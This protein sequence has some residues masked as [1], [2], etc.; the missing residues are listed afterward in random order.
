MTIHTDQLL[1]VDGF[2]LLSRGYFATSYGKE[3]EQLTKNEQG[4]Y[5]NGVRVF[6]QKLCQLT[7]ENPY[8]HL[9]IA[10]DVKREDSIRR[11]YAPDYKGTRGELPEPLIEQYQTCC[12]LL[13]DIGIQQLTIPPYEADDI[14]GAITK[15]WNAE[16]ASLSAI[17]SNDR[18]LL[19][20][21]SETTT[22]IIAMKGKD[23]AIQLIDFQNQYGIT[24]T[25]WIDVKA[26][27]GDK[28]D[29]IPG[30]AGVGEKSA[31]PLIQQ[32][33]TVEVLYEKLANQEIDL[34]FKRYLKKLEAG[35][36]S[37]LLSKKLA[38]IICEIEEI[39]TYLLDEAKLPNDKEKIEDI[40]H[41]HGLKIQYNPRVY[42]AN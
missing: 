17:Y 15:K 38:T 25:Q 30:C 42:V 9:I 21:I 32:Y 5:I 4:Q 31:L 11:Q 24:P 35:Y 14:I 8:S 1:I 37:V 34:S 27:L 7:R 18:D 26:L 20:L 28:S 23:T 3:P 12:Q 39:N 13:E 19:Q 41:T 36:E 16:K 6:F 2:N 29:N 40:F 10:W 33:G 22:Q